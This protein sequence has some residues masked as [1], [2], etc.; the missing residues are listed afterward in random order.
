M[1]K[2]VVLIICVSMGISASIYSQDSI[3]FAKDLT[4]EKNL[5]F[6]ESFFKALSHKAVRNYQKAIGS[7][8]NC[9]EILPNN[10]TVYFEFSK[11]YFFLNRPQLAKEYILRA[12]EKKP[13][14]VWMQLH[15][16][17]I[18]K[19]EKKYKEACDKLE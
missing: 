8:E 17:K 4:E 18:L 10:A 9:N 15:L 2:R 16:V 11:N 3:P 12:L 1:L 13:K 14:D 19:K 5:K 6:Q 7:L